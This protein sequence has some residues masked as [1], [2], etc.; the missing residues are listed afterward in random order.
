MSKAKRRM[1]YKIMT[2]WLQFFIPWLERRTWYG[3]LR[4][5]LSHKLGIGQWFQ[6]HD[7][8]VKCGAEAGEIDFWMRRT[9]DGVVCAD[10]T[11]C[12]EIVKEHAND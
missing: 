11:L 5:W 3:D 1:K 2:Y 8:C 9:A 10:E 4:Y 12:A 6:Y 7:C